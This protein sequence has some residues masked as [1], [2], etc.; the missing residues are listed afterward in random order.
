MTELAAPVLEQRLFNLLVDDYCHGAAWEQPTG[1]IGSLPASECKG[2][3]PALSRVTDD[4]PSQA[5][6]SKSTRAQVNGERF[7]S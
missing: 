5:F 2:G 1:G 6:A 7:S 3:P 4:A